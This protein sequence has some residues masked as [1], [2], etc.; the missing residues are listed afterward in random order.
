VVFVA[1]EEVSVA[2]EG[3]GD[4]GVAMYVLRAFV[5]MPAAIM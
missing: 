3:D 4:A 1:G 5:L 2:V